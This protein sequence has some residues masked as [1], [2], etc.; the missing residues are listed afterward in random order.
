MAERGRLAQC[1]RLLGPGGHYGSGA[2]HGRRTGQAYEAFRGVR[3]RPRSTAALGFLAVALTA[4]ASQYQLGWRV[5]WTGPRDGA[6]QAVTARQRTRH[7]R[8]GMSAAATVTRSS[9]AGTV[10][11][12]AHL[13]CRSAGTR[14]PTLAHRH[15]TTCGSLDSPVREA[16]KSRC[17]SM[18]GDGVPLPA[19]RSPACYAAR[20]CSDRQ[21]SG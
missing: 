12:G 15:H 21:M 18:A 17:G 2:R 14:R 4:Q 5:T 20:P 16:G 1:S 7:G 10:P 3:G 8:S 19:R 13:P 6:L 11:G 9:S